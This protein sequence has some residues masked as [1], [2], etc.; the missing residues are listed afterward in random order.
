MATVQGFMTL[1][2]NVRL[3][4][5]NRQSLS[6]CAEK[7]WSIARSRHGS[8]NMGKS[9]GW[10]DCSYTGKTRNRMSYFEDVSS[11]NS[12]VVCRVLLYKSCMHGEET[13]R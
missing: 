12:L 3:D 9:A 7:G 5:S 1:W 13:R 4:L 8:E 10:V 6:I 11:S 2:C